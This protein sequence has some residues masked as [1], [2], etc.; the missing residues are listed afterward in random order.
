MEEFAQKLG[1][2]GFDD[3][4]VKIAGANISLIC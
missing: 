3:K 1:D 4:A 2:R